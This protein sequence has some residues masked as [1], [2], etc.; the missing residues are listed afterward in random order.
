MTLSS[1]EALPWS[2]WL[3][4]KYDRK[5][6]WKTLSFNDALPWSVAFVENNISKWYWD[7]INR[8]MSIPWT[9][10]LITKFELYLPTEWSKE[11]NKRM[12]SGNSLVEW[13]E[14]LIERFR[15]KWD[16]KRLSEN[17]SL[18]WT[19]EFIDNYK[20]EWHWDALS[21]NCALPWSEQLLLKYKNKWKWKEDENSE[22]SSI[23]GNNYIPWSNKMLL[24]F[25]P[26][27][28]GNYRNSEIDHIWKILEPFVDDDL[29]KEVLEEYNKMQ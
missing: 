20:D 11:H 3:L 29:I 15:D 9:E 24:D 5:W 17:I 18:P 13:S 8:K 27:Y 28:H 12:L 10:G 23:F 16:W 25:V 2:E 4:N 21:K 19:V 6:D 14:N 26:L 7:G 22:A 1:N